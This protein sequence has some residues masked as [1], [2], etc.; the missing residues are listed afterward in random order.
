VVRMG[1]KKCVQ[2][3]GGETFGTRPLERRRRDWMDNIRNI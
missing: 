2:D 1:G 3:A